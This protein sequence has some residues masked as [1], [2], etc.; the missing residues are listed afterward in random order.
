LIYISLNDAVVITVLTEATL[1]F[2][3]FVGFE[4]IYAFAVFAV[5]A[6]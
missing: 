2:Y 3:H 5:V 1:M 4:I 6:A